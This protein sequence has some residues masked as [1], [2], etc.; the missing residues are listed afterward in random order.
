MMLTGG[1]GVSAHLTFPNRYASVG[2]RSDG[3]YA[4]SSSAQDA[5]LTCIAVKNVRRRGR[6]VE[7]AELI[8]GV[9]DRLRR[10]SSSDS[11]QQLAP[12]WSNAAV[13]C[14]SST[15]P[16]VQVSTN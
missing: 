4:S 1:V 12:G 10:C 9:R 8:G 7:D 2:S 3:C 6:G 15:T 13:L 16:A 5:E 14:S 11:L